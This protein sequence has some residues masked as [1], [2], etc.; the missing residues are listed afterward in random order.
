MSGLASNLS[1]CLTISFPFWLP[2]PA[3][4]VP[5]SKTKSSTQI[6]LVLLIDVAVSRFFIKTLSCILNK[7][8][9]SLSLFL[10]ICAY[11]HIYLHCI[12]NVF[13]TYPFCGGKRKR[14]R[15]DP[16]SRRGCLL[17]LFPLALLIQSRMRFHKADKYKADR[18]KSRALSNQFPTDWPTD[19][20]TDQPT[21]GR[22][23]KASYRIACPQL[24]SKSVK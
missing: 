3:V 4:V 8:G 24:K 18:H 10:S 7:F 23:D 17:T 20:P 15:K 6:L 16:V 22:T 19:R 11:W 12:V 13:D 1:S 5:H 2:P 14:R 21:D 9:S